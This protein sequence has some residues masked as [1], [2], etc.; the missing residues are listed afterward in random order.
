MKPLAPL[1]LRMLILSFTEWALPDQLVS[2][3]V[4]ALLRIASLHPQYRSA[5][6]SAI[7]DFAS[8]IIDQLKK[9]YCEK[10]CIY[11]DMTINAF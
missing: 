9:E 10:L 7:L 6:T 11:W 2:T 1:D 4:T 3:T 5:A 8:K